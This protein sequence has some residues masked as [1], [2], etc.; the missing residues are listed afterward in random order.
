MN[1]FGASLAG[2][3]TSG[4]IRSAIY[5]KGKVDYA[6]IAADAFGN[7]VGN[8]VVGQITPE[9]TPTEDKTNY[10]FETPRSAISDPLAEYRAGAR[11][12]YQLVPS[13]TQ[14]PRLYAGIA[15]D[16]NSVQA[17]APGDLEAFLREG[18]PPGFLASS[19]PPDY[20]SPFEPVASA[21][22]AVPLVRRQSTATQ[23]DVRRI[24]NEIAA[25]NAGVPGV[26]ADSA[27]GGQPNTQAIANPTVQ[28]P[29]AT[30]VDPS[31]GM[32]PGPTLERAQ[33]MFGVKQPY[34]IAGQ[35]EVD[36]KWKLVSSMLGMVSDG[37]G[38]AQG[39]AIT[40]V[41]A[42]LTG[43][44]EPTTLTK[45]LGVPLTIYGAATTTKSAG[46]FMLNTTNFFQALRGMSRESDYVPGGVLEGAVQ[47]FGGSKELERAAVATDL[48]WD[49]STGRAMKASLSMG[50]TLNPRV[51]ALLQPAPV[52][53]G[54]TSVDGQM[55]KVF[56]PTWN[57]AFRVEPAFSVMNLGVKVQESIVD[58]LR[59]RAQ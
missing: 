22:G 54:T 6:S 25:R 44:P 4:L 35:A 42:G 53:L 8:S 27:L 1:S 38:V 24:D 51:A 2:G 45:W 15:P 26:V 56:G 46:G 52:S 40:L 48:A 14:A 9:P 11:A 43:A 18:L 30:P 31:D 47:M 13:G 5:N 20:T 55:F 33:R 29:T 49:L 37:F 17:A 23:A 3:L 34:A 59:A 12:D 28:G 36:W 41:G 16:N 50:S 57:S 39:A 19:E 58:P 10:L 7:A 21:E 32:P